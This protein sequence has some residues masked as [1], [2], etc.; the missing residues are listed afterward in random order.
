M[1]YLL[2]SGVLLAAAC[3]TPRAAAGDDRKELVEKKTENTG[4]SSS[5]SSM[6][7][8]MQQMMENAARQAKAMQDAAR[9]CEAEIP[10]TLTEEQVTAF[11]RER[12]A[13]F[14]TET[15]GTLVDN[16]AALKE[17]TRI[18]GSVSQGAAN[19]HFGLVTSDAVR[20]FSS[21][22]GTVLV[23]TG[24]LKKCANEA[25]LAGVLAHEVD[26]VAKRADQLPHVKSLRA[27]CQAEKVA[28]QMGMNTG[29]NDMLAGMM[30]GLE[31]MLRGGESEADAAALKAL[32]AAG[33]EPSEYEALIVAI[34]NTD[35]DGVT[36]TPDG[37][38]HRAEKLK[39]ARESMI[40]KN[41]KK[42]ALPKSLSAL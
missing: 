5:A 9:E 21:S 22:D 20:A 37:A 13:G 14:L 26:H 42:P 11:G 10:E 24:L 1:K 31:N 16:A 30:G 23:T 28:R 18:G 19:L 7:L 25:Q 12:A 32:V 17:L 27:K 41:H 3:A 36:R 39:A 38:A 15:K 34:G 33:Y 2:F 40:I 29:S 8:N 35:Q 6:Q 4:S